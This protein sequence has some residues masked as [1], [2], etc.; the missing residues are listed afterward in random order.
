MEIIR[1]VYVEK[2]LR[3]IQFSAQAVM[4][5]FIGSVVEYKVGLLTHYIS[6]VTSV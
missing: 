4:H 6:S 1:V 3:G 2:E 5:R